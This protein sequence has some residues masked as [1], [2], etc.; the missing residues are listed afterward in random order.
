MR[1]LYF[2]L[3]KCLNFKSC[4]TNK[5]TRILVMERLLRLNGTCVS[6]T[7]LYLKV[8]GSVDFAPL[9]HYSSQMEVESSLV[10]LPDFKSGVPG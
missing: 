9:K 8:S 4:N 5:H 2:N 3:K 6:F 10:G 1:S 7:G